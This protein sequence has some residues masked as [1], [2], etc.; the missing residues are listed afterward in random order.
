MLDSQLSQLSR[1]I[2][3]TADCLLRGLYVRAKYRD[4]ILPITV[5]HSPDAVL[6]PTKEE[7]LKQKERSR[8]HQ[9]TIVKGGGK[10]YH[11]GE[12]KVYHRGNG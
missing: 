3:N 8:I 6:E 5:S 1:F 11:C 12:E 7:V 9:G 10:T 2:W 4:V